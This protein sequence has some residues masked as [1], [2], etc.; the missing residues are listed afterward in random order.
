MQ[1][2]DPKLLRTDAYIDGKWV[3][4]K[5]RFAVT[6][7]ANGEVIAEVADLGASDV[8]AAIDG[9]KFVMSSGAIGSGK[10]KLY[11]IKDS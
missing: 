8:T 7:P 5:K 1:L 3:T 4:P 10:I 11:G 2:N 6:N 9:V